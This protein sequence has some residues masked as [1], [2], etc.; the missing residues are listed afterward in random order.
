[1]NEPRNTGKWKRLDAPRTDWVCVKMVD[2][3]DAFFPVSG[4]C[5]MC[6]V[7]HITHGHAM[8][9]PQYLYELVCGCICA[10]YMADNPE[11]AQRR[12]AAYKAWR[13]LRK[14]PDT[15]KLRRKGWNQDYTREGEYKFS[16]SNE[17]N[18]KW[19]VRV[20]EYADTGWI[21]LINYYGHLVAGTE[22][23][24]DWRRAALDA[25]VTVEALRGDEVQLAKFE[26]TRAEENTARELRNWRNTIKSLRTHAAEYP[27]VLAV[28]DQLPDKKDFSAYQ[29]ICS[30]LDAA[31]EVPR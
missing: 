8:R 28:I 19:V 16:P 29:K 15:G 24:E 4:L 6:E 5:E 22:P 12:D 14:K 26:R 10:G 18:L 3:D 2:S 13:E 31:R 27:E 7:T 30:L 23:A 9:H 20:H 1:M 11:E 17:Y 21:G 25:L